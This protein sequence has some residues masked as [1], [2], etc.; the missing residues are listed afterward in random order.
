MTED[1]DPAVDQEHELHPNTQHVED[2]SDVLVS[3]A[4]AGVGRHVEQVVGDNVDDDGVAHFLLITPDPDEPDRCGGCATEW[5]C[6]KGVSL[7]VMEQPPVD[8]ALVAAVAEALRKERELGH[9][10]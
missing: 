3:T 6:G 2:L 9:V 4:G 10:Q 7:Q 8:P 5:P 1:R